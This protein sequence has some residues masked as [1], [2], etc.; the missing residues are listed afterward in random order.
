M[1]A[2]VMCRQRLL[3]PN[4]QEFLKLSGIFL[5]IKCTMNNTACSYNQYRRIYE[6][7]GTKTRK[8]HSFFLSAVITKLMIR[9]G[10]LRI[11][12]DK[13][14]SNFLFMN[15]MEEWD[16]ELVEGKAGAIFSLFTH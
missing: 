14:S 9:I 7:I 3:T 11:C 10:P 8:I 16:F 2:H 4:Y 12:S 6:Y 1:G 5:N 15:I 13:E